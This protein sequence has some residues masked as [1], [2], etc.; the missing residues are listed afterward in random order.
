MRL[1]AAVIKEAD[2]LMREFD[3]SPSRLGRTLFNDPSF[4]T[5][6]RNPKTRVT[7]KTLDTIFRYTVQKRGQVEMTQIVGNKESMR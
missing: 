4:F 2:E 1:K 6:L 3:I 7:D 5:R